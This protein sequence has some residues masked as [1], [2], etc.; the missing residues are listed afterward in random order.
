LH[1]DIKYVH[2][3]LAKMPGVFR[4][5]GPEKMKLFSDDRPDLALRGRLDFF[6]AVAGARTAVPS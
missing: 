5:L 2:A 6:T 3:F 1:G 4:V